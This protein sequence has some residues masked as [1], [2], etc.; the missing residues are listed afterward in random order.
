[1]CSL[2]PLFYEAAV[3]RMALDQRTPR[4]EMNQDFFLSVISSV[5]NVSKLTYYF[6]S[7]N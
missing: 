3:D 6:D 1:M 7:S 2:L 5:I 4:N